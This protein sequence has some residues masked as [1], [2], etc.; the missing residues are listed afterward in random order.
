MNSKETIIAAF[1]I[2]ECELGCSEDEAKSSY[3]QLV[4]VWHP[5]RFEGDPKLKIKAT[6]K[7]KAINA[8]YQLVLEF[9]A[10]LAEIEKN[11]TSKQ[12]ASD[13]HQTN[14]SKTHTQQKQGGEAEHKI[15]EEKIQ[16]VQVNKNP[17]HICY[18][19]HVTTTLGFNGRW[20][21]E[22]TVIF[23][24]R[25]TANGET[26]EQLAK[27]SMSFF[28]KR[29]QGV[30]GRHWDYSSALDPNPEYVGS[31]NEYDFPDGSS[32]SYEDVSTDTFFD[33][34]EKIANWCRKSFKIKDL[35][36]VYQLFKSKKD[37]AVCVEVAQK[38]VDLHSKNA[39]GWIQRSYALHFLKKTRDAYEL[40]KPAAKLFPDKITVFYNLACYAAQLG[41]ANEA[42]LWLNSVFE[43]A[44]KT[45]PYSGTFERYRKQALEDA[46]LISIRE[47]VPQMP[48]SWKVR[49]YF[50]V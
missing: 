26:F 37:W 25:P 38:A 33:D 5:D 2:L 31:G 42:K 47:G 28:K 4:K 21:T 15:G 3:R 48:L 45:G 34:D 24:T 18:E 39:W 32:L 29:E 22:K 12:Q 35:E 16:I 6:E 30:L 49:K 14:Q 11:S 20:L 40:L 43:L 19:K 9:Y 17:G 1:V 7:L 8:A 23:K 10:E 50:G 27:D 13:S 41:N 36:E 44:E 46:D